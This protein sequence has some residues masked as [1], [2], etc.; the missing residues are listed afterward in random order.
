[1]PTS[2]M[3][4][5]LDHLHK[6]VGTTTMLDL[7]D[8]ELLE[9]FFG[10][11]EEAAFTVLLQRHGPAV[12]GV[13]R[14]I[15]E[16]AHAAEDA[17]QATFLVLLRKAD[18]VRKRDSLGS[19]LHGVAYR[20]AMRARVQAGER[21][22]RE[23]QAV[24]PSSLPSAFEALSRAEAC[25]VLHEEMGHLADKYR[26]PLVLCHLEGKT[27]EQ[28][29][30]ELGWPKSSVS[31][32]LKRGCELLRQ[33]LSQRGVALPA[34]TLALLLAEQTAGAVP[35]L[36]TLTTVR[37]A[38]E[39][40]AG[41]ASP[42]KAAVG[43]AG[44][45]LK[46]VTATHK[47]SLL[48]LLLMIGLAVTGVGVLPSQTEQ[49]RTERPPPGMHATRQPVEPLKQAAELREFIKNPQAEPGK[50]RVDR[51][52]DPLPPGAVTRL[53]TVRFRNGTWDFPQGLVFLPDGKT[54]VSANSGQ[55]IQFWEVASGRLL[56]TIS[57]EEYQVQC[58]DLSRDGK[59]LAAAGVRFPR[60]A[61]AEKGNV[62]LFDVATG[63]VIATFPRES[64]E[65]FPGSLAFTP[66]GTFLLSLD[67]S[68]IVRIEEVASGKELL[69]QKFGQEVSGCLALSPDG[70]TVALATGPNTF[71]SKLY[72][73][74][75]QT[76]REPREVKT[77]RLRWPRLSSSHRTVRCW[78]NGERSTTPSACGTW[79]PE[80]SSTNS[81]SREKRGIGPPNW[82][83]PWTGRP[84]PSAHTRRAGVERSTS[85]IRGRCG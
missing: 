65:A 58:L 11:H 10:R 56:R 76:G 62:R 78:P 5:V 41:G 14:G 21:R 83:S 55:G 8:A 38:A 80:S 61:L 73:W 74:E 31:A 59:R 26:R 43:L 66:D 79:S 7:S 39:T 70:S 46:A 63:K 50:G 72:L 45:V 68:G 12:L 67:S 13:C 3:K 64:R 19:F 27:H 60:G 6:R 29:A 49:S 2:A 53:G 44:G 36:L 75:W 77:P 22:A 37:V 15:L 52:G 17:F 9:R 33:R 16:D 28:V 85:G 57:T 40:L 71:K 54:L 47:G 51:F 34:G 24:A 48:A 81:K 30:D 20:T 35:A 32:R 82:P 84:W 4:R 69:Q 18:S 23:R 1:M 25:A 42:E